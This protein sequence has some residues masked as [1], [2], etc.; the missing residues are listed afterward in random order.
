M[1][2]PTDLSRERL[3]R[4]DARA[5]WAPQ[6]APGSAAM[7]GQVTT[8]APVVGK[9]ILVHPVRVLGTESE[10]A[11]GVT[12][13]DTSVSVPVYLIGP[14]APS[15]GELLVCRFVD[16]R[17]VTTRKGTTSTTHADA[18]CVCN[19]M[20]NN[21]TLTNHGTSGGF[22]WNAT[23]NYISTPAVLVAAG[24]ASAGTALWSTTSFFDNNGFEFYYNVTCDPS[25]HFV[26]L[27]K[28]YTTVAHDNFYGGTAAWRWL[29]GFN[30]NT[31]SPFD[32]KSGNVPGNPT[33]STQMELTSP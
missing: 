33:Q 24:T 10:G 13:V 21:C 27:G 22:L 8:A 7:V 17:W 23:I 5:G 32:M 16:Y 25:S 26:V 15:T 14:G 29:P 19:P 6:A 12:A 4:G 30:G 31:C 1:M 3:R 9:Y 18:N 11:S 20:P 28:V 2:A